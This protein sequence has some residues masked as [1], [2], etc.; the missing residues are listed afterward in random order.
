MIDIELLRSDKKAVEQSLARRG[1]T[2]DIDAVLSLDDTRRELIAEIDVLRRGSNEIAKRGADVSS[3]DK[4]KGKSLK[5]KVKIKQEELDNVNAQLKERMAQIPNIPLKEV[6]DGVEGEILRE[7]GEVKQIISSPKDH[8]EL[9]QNLDLIDF[10]AGAKVSGSQFYFLKNEAALLEIALVSFAITYLKNRGFTPILTPDLVRERF[11]KGTGFQ[12]N[13][14][15]A[16][17]YE[18]KDEDLGLVATAE[19]SMAGYHADEVFEPDSLP[20]RY[21]AL[22]H[23][24]RKEAGAYGKYSK[25]LYRVHQFT[26]VEMFAYTEPD[27]SERMHQEF[28]ECE[29]AIFQELD[30]PYRVRLLGV[31]DMGSQSAKTYDLE[32]W[33]PGRGEWG[34][35]TST[36]NTTDFQARNMNIKYRSPKGNSYVHMLNGTA[37]A[38]SRALIAILENY[39]RDDGGIDIP[40]V[41]QPYCGTGA[42]MPIDA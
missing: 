27:E 8:V 19:V 29:E 35:V 28:L 1:A 23:C 16:Q 26:K 24:F 7:W 40:K 14:P 15:E 22:S 39:Q 18:I 33:M 37:I 6:P 17:I 4:E 5:E 31:Q 30:I 2:I 32:A 25:G 3:E 34:E 42:I 38:T 10:E 12:P 9:S 11:Y 20:K 21:V 36:S 13:G 41:L